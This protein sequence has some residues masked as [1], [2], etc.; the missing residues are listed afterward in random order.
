MSKLGELW[1]KWKIH[2]SLAGG[3]LVIATAYG[4]CYYE[5]QVDAETPAVEESE[6]ES[7]PA[8]TNGQES[9]VVEAVTETPTEPLPATTD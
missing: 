2:V 3:V 7:E 9:D 5:P 1:E 6:A 8:S 4:T